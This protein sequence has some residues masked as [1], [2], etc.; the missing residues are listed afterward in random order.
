MR[1]YQFRDIDTILKREF[2]SNVKDIIY[3]ISFKNF[4]KIKRRKEKRLA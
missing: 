1:E 4:N 3:I 2:S